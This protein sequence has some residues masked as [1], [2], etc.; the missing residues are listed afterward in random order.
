MRALSACKQMRIAYQRA[1][2]IIW[3]AFLVIQLWKMRANSSHDARIVIECTEHSART[4]L[5][6]CT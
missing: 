5:T 2:P 6:K 3:R 1:L 4:V